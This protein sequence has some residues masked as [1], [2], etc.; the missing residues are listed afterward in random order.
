MLKVETTRL[1]SSLGVSGKKRRNQGITYFKVL[2]K[3]CLQSKTISSH[4]NPLLS[5]LLVQQL[6]L[7]AIIHAKHSSWY[8]RYIK[9]QRSLPIFILSCTAYLSMSTIHTKFY[10]SQYQSLIVSDI[11][12]LFSKQTVTFQKTRDPRFQF[13]IILSLVLWGAKVTVNICFFHR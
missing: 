7:E 2:V 12:F 11:L 10:V 6:F 9:E 3:P 8:L 13:T 1:A 4:S 5:I